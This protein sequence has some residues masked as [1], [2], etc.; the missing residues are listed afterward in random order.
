MA[1][2]FLHQNKDNY[3]LVWI[4]K[5]YHTFLQSCKWK[6]FRPKVSPNEKNNERRITM[7]PAVQTPVQMREPQRKTT[8]GTD[9]GR[10]G[11][12]DECSAES[13]LSKLI[14]HNI[15]CAGCS[16]SP[17]R[18]IYPYWLLCLVPWG[19]SDSHQQAPGLPTFSL[20]FL[21]GEGPASAESEGG[22]TKARESP[23]SSS[24]PARHS[25]SD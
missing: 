10:T 17:S 18:P 20:G 24:L 3:R 6:R 8:R 13:W 14:R 1:S 19:T 15:P 21:S 23:T 4:W 2:P 11:E 9:L 16:P 12:R 7:Q 5:I 22:K 25:L